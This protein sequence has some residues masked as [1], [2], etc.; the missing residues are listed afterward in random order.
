MAKR[1]LI[2][3]IS[4]LFVAGSSLQAGAIN[5][6]SGLVVSTLSYE[7]WDG[8]LVVIEIEHAS[9]FECVK[10]FAND[11]AFPCEFSARMRANSDDVMVDLYVID[12]DGESVG[13]IMLADDEYA[14]GSWL[15]TQWQEAKIYISEPYTSKTSTENYTFSTESYYFG[16]EPMVP[17]IS[18]KWFQFPNLKSV[19]SKRLNLKNSKVF[20]NGT[21]ASLPAN[22]KAPKNGCGAVPVKYKISNRA[23]QGYYN[24]AVVIEDSKGKY[25]GAVI[26]RS[27]DDGYSGTVQIPVCSYEWFADE[28]EEVVRYAVKPG[29]YKVS[30]LEW[31]DYYFRSG[32]SSKQTLTFKK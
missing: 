25:V 29:K 31:D 8:T 13:S 23:L 32:Q 9:D 4:L 19:G 30:I 11:L 1:F 12:E 28:Y 24:H 5:K 27:E 26:L 3:L 20:S 16:S 22:L 10:A 18:V 6:S 15:T 17:L 2:G 7:E 21:T 14:V